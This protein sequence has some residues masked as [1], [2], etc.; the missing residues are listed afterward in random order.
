MRSQDVLLKLSHFAYLYGNGIEVKVI[1]IHWLN[2]TALAQTF[3]LLG[4]DWSLHL[5]W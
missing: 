3:S 2:E 4:F 1:S 5:M